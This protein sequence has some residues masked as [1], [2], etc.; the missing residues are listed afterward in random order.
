VDW[1]VEDAVGQGTDLISSMIARS[2]LAHDLPGEIWVVPSFGASPGDYIPKLGRC[3]LDLPRKEVPEP[4]AQRLARL[5]EALEAATQ[6]N[7]V[8]LDTRS[9]LHDLASAVVTEL[10][11]TVLLFGVGSEQTW[12]AYRLL[13][14][15]WNR[16]GV[17]QAIRE[18]LQVVAAL[19]PE[20]E[21]EEYLGQFLNSA[22][23]LFRD[24]LYDVLGGGE[25]DGFSFDLND[26]SAPHH[27]LPIYWHRG[28]ASLSSFTV[29][30]S[31]LVDAAFGSFLRGLDVM[32]ADFGRTT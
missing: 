26:D 21:R 28:L 3:Y 6:P 23:N 5:L 9:G 8:L 13:F 19:V 30:D 14:E 20:T 11:H 7:V 12:S 27:P 29:M 10:A 17:A 2:S 4:W 1:F 18:R 16:F 32:L 15:H 31:Q 24:E 22:W 25:I